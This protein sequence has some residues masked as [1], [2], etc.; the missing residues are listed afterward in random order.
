MYRRTRAVLLRPAAYRP[1]RMAQ[2]LPNLAMHTVRLTWPAFIGLTFVT[3][4]H[5][6]GTMDFSGATTLM[7]TFKAVRVG[8]FVLG[9]DEP[10]LEI[11][12]EGKSSISGPNQANSSARSLRC[13]F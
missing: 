10:L 7:Q 5:A 1:N 13:C 9:N 12:P 6:Q 2:S 3:T 8:L 11:V 4:A